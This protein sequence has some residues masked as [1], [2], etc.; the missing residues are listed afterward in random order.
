[1]LLVRGNKNIFTVSSPYY[2]LFQ[3]RKAAEAKPD[4]HLAE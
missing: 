3:K 4:E 1:L 2:L